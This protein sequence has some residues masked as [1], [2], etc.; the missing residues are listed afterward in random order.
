MRRFQFPLEAA[1]KLRRRNV[2]GAEAAL[3]QI[4][5][6]RMAAIRQAAALE[7]ESAAVRESIGRTHI[8][9]GV[10]LHRADATSRALLVQARAAHQAARN[11][12]G[13]M[14]KA[15]AALLHAR[16]DAET[17]ERLREQCL[18]EWRQAAGRE[19]EAVAAELFLARFA[20]RDNEDR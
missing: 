18:R 10:D 11:L 20:K 17:L 19:E 16:R 15:R 8:L 2:E 6:R 13:E 7:A 14:H 9:R 5:G 12:D 4:E 3:A 1:L